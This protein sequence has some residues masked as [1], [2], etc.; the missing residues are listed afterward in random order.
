MSARGAVARI[1]RSPCCAAACYC[2]VLQD[3]ILRMA[4]DSAVAKSTACDSFGIRFPDSGTVEQ[5]SSA[6]G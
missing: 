2:E 6:A 5:F 4:L 3:A 1:H